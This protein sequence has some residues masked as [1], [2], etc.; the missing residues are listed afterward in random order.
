MSK[1]VPGSALDFDR[2][3]PYVNETWQDSRIVSIGGGA[4]AR[5]R[6]D[7]FHSTAIHDMV[8]SAW[9][10]ELLSLSL[11]RTKRSMAGASTS[12]AQSMNWFGKIMFGHCKKLVA[13][14]NWYFIIYYEAPAVLLT[15]EWHGLL[16]LA[17][18]N[19][20][21]WLLIVVALSSC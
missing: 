12:S 20:G 17:Q 7:C 18:N 3:W 13:L 10:W 15:F 21:L 14:T 5:V 19:V 2:F 6:L 4:C 9:R 8:K 11:H 16:H 1:P